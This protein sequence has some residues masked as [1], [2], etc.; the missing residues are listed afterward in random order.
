MGEDNRTKEEK[1]KQ[2]KAVKKA[3]LLFNI[4]TA[5]PVG[6]AESAAETI[7]AVADTAETA[8]AADETPS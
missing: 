7:G 5:D 4:F 3:S 8:D 6:V 2:Y 1:A